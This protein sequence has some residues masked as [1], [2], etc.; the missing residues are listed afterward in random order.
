MSTA[1]EELRKAVLK[2]NA[3]KVDA[4][5]DEEADV[6]LNA[7]VDSR[8]SGM[9]LL[10]LAANHN[11]SGMIAKAL[12]DRGATVDAV[13]GKIDRTPLHFASFHNAIQVALV[14]LEARA[15]PNFAD[16]GGNRPL[17]LAASNNCVAVANALLSKG[18]ARD[19]T[20]KRGDTALDNAVNAKHRAMSQLLAGNSVGPRLD[21]L[22]DHLSGTVVT[23][24]PLATAMTLNQKH[25]NNSSG[26][27]EKYKNSTAIGSISG[28]E[29]PSLDESACCLVS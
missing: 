3:P 21:V 6:D 22:A 13:C 15:D 5:L 4:L 24:S 12:I 14:L 1:F 26:A 19:A 20:N 17:H 28:K 9:T 8:N 29:I 27:A 10:H 18:A 2:G 7:D 11:R 25:S 23:A 16:K